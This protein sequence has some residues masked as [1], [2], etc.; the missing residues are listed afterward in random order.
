[1]ETI[2]YDYNRPENGWPQPGF[3]VTFRAK[4]AGAPG[5]SDAVAVSKNSVQS[6][7]QWLHL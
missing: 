5:K 4:P 6:I 3:T 7:I 1:V 2:T